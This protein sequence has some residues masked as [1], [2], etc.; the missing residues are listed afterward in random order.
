VLRFLLMVAV[1]LVAFVIFRETGLADRMSLEALSTAVGTVRGWWWS[2]LALIGIWTLLSPLGLPGSVPLLAGAVVFGPWW[3][4]LYNQIGA[5]L[6]AVTSF[7]FAR[8]LG[9]DLVAHLLGEERLARMERRMAH[10]G[11]WSLLT[12]RMFPIPFALFNFGA[13]LAGVTLGQ[14]TL[15]TTLGLAPQLFVWNFFYAS[16]GSATASHD[17]QTLVWIVVAFA[18]LLGL[19]LFRLVLLRRSEPRN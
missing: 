15:S 9:H 18:L 12:L 2:P 6:G 10:Y 19:G 3:G 4:F 11:F 8:L 14:F 7:L 16:L 5:T 1:L 17:R 13:A